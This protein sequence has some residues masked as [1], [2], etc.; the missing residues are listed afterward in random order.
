M[1]LAIT[2]AVFLA[3]LCMMEGLWMSVRARVDNSPR[4]M[5]D[6]LRVFSED[7]IEVRNTDILRKRTLSTVPWLNS[8]L[9]RVNVMQRLDTILEQSNVKRPLGVIV[10]LSTVL[11]VTG[12]FVGTTVRM[13]FVMSC[14]IAVVLGSIPFLYILFKRKRRMQKFERQLPEV[15]DLIARSLRAGHAFATGL[16]MV[17]QEFDDP[18][19]TEFLKTERQLRLGAGVEQ[20]LKALTERVPCQDLK[21]FAVAVSI[22]RETGGNLAEILESMGSL[23]RSRF[24]LRGKVKAL[25]AESKFSALVLLALPFVVA[26]VLLALSPSYLDVLVEDPLGK[27]LMYGA[28]LMLGVGIAV[29]KKMVDVK[30]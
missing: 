14:L 28:L 15:L 4:K 20:V 25:S 12:I 16:H 17:A 7:Q 18:V 3:V 30:V 21:F 29:I 26:G 11:A 1:T 23:I 24:K 22:Q 6:K 13:S 8:L 10:L 2:M 27:V 19:G 5:R 9:S